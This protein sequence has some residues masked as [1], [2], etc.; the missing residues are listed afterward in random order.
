M[1]GRSE[2][3]VFS[4]ATCQKKLSFI[5][6]STACNCNQHPK[7]QTTVTSKIARYRLLFVVAFLVFVLDQI[8]KTWIFYNLELDSYYPPDSIAVI[9]DFF[10]IV[11]IGNE[12]AAWGMLSGYSGILAFFAM[13]ALIAIYLLRHTLELHRLSLI[14]I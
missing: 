5:R 1:S 3:R 6:I 12:G 10:Y 14:H 11:H 2:R 4:S 13:F 8:T 9:S 7:V